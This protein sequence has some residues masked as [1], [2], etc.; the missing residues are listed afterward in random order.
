MLFWMTELSGCGGRVEELPGA[1]WVCELLTGLIQ[2][3]TALRVL[4]ER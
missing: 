4:N 2:E 3:A 1:P